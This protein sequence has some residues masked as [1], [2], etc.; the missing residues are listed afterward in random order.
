M[1]LQTRLRLAI[2]SAVLVAV[3]LSLLV[4]AF[5]V[6]R[7]LEQAAFSG[8]KRQV[9]LLAH[10]DLHPAPGQFGRFLATQDERLSVLPQQ[11]AR[12]LLPDRPAGRITINEH[13]YLYATKDSGPDVVVLLRTASSV[14][15]EG[16]PFWVALAAAGALGCLLATAAAAMLAR[17]IARPVLRVARASSRLAE[18]RH[19]EPLP[20][21]GPSELR[22]LAESFNTMAGQ[23]TRARDAERSFL[24]SVS[25]ELKTP[26]TAIRGY[27]EDLDEGV[28]TPERAVK[29]IRTEAARLER[30]I[31]DILNLA[32]LDQQRF[33]I[34]LETVDLAEIARES[35]TRHAARARDLGVRIELQEGASSPTKADPDRLLQAVSNLVENA[36]RC[37]PP[38]GTVTLAAAGS[39]L[40]VKDTGPGIAP[41]EIPHAFDRFF[42]YRRYNGDRPVGTG[43]GLAI[44][45]ELVQAMGGEAR[46]AASSTGTE[47]TI[48]LPLAEGENQL[49][50]LHAFTQS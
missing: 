28:L 3:S 6:R 30:L 23:L 9:T 47:F 49:D 44:V 25:H 7:S 27:S 45:R 32:R 5:L 40:T 31:A 21:A 2:G 19:P 36:L 10:E 33:D 37:T 18:G 26:L 14:R 48:C 43:L 42:L 15:S 29:V 22:S 12:L 8:L 11:Q 41:D 16:K 24:L 34:H 46:V 38:G 13:D 39:E 17:S 1:S 50:A 35:A 4:G 20:L